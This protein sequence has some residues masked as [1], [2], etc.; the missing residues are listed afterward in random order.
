[1]SR[2]FCPGG[3]RSSITGC[4]PRHREKGRG[5][6]PVE[7]R[8]ELTPQEFRERYFVPGIPVVLEGAAAEWP[9][10]KKWTPDYLSR[11]CG[12][13]ETK[14]LDG[15]NWTVNRD[16]GQEAVSTA[17]NLVPIHDLM[18]SV[19]A[20]GAWY[21][22]FMELLDT[23]ADLRQDL[24]LSFVKR[25]GHTNRH[26]PGSGTSSRGCTSVD[27]ARRRRFTAPA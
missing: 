3:G 25:F 10:I 19:T 7:R 15:R 22:A 2:S 18:R 20:G 9:A 14:V 21:G 16:A 8:C 26:I 4:W 23:H 6:Y 13:E 5:V 12:N 17:E 27:R 1:M 11:L 24:D